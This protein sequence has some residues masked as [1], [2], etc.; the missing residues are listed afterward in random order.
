MEKL[1]DFLPNDWYFFLEAEFK[2]K[3]F[4]E[5]EKFVFSEYQKEIVFPDL[6]NIFA[7]FQQTPVAEISVLLLGQDPYHGEGQAHG[8][9]FSVKNG[10]K[11]PPSLKNIFKELESDLGIK[12]SANG[13]LT[14]WARQ[15]VLLLN[16]VLTVRSGPPASHKNKGWEKFTDAVIQNLSRSK[17]DLVF[18]LWGNYAKNKKKLIDPLKHTIIE[19]VHPSPLSANSGFFGSKPFSAIN[20]SLSSLGKKIINWKI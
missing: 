19:G 17:K 12:N 20:H 10:T 7:S 4:Q 8:L 11:L 1:T 18:V 14:V 5:L 13:D 3:Y 16:S 6:E 9:S 2:Q 15:G